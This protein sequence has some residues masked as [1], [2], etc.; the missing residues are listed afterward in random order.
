ML[1]K[2]IAAFCVATVLT[3]LLVVGVLAVRGNL[4]A[5]STTKI[6]GLMNGIDISGDRVAD[7]IRAAK[8]EPI[9]SFEEVL[10]ERARDGLEMDLRRRAQ[11]NYYNQLQ[12]VQE[13]LRSKE[14]RFDT[15]KDAF[16]RKLAELS[17]G[18]QDEAMQS[19]Q[20]TLES[21]PPATSKDQL[22]RML[23]GGDLNDVVAIVKAMQA[24]KRKK[25]L[26][27]FVSPEEADKLQ[28]IL[29]HIGAGEPEK[30]VIDKARDE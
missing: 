9:P 8:T 21:L 26:R 23:D 1:T 6:V 16:Y 30:T 11:E 27:E 25:I 22:I 20:S 13:R 3:Q 29:N 24:D 7:S 5:A 28:Q 18:V 19:L 17:Q 4:N 12:V 14:S 15:R 2:G 10:A